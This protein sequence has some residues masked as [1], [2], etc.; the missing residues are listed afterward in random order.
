MK[1]K[2][3][4]NSRDFWN[5]WGHCAHTTHTHTHTLIHTV[6]SWNECENYMDERYT[7]YKLVYLYM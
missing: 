6:I 2:P 4:L 3:I 7:S 5:N 1:E